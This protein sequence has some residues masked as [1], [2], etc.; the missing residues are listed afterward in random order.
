MTVRNQETEL[1]QIAERIRMA[2]K[3]AHLSQAALASGV[4]VSDKA[5]SSYEQ[6]RSTPP[7]EKLQRIAIQTNRPVS[8]F[9]SESTEEIT[10]VTKL[11]GIERELEE[12]KELLKRSR[13]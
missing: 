1:V 7:F 10:I 9:T 5:I 2:R 13:K 11:Q 8:Y 3:D 6:G 12:I 4:G